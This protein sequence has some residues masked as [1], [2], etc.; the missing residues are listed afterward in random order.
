[1]SA[2]SVYGALGKYATSDFTWDD[3]GRVTLSGP[4]VNPSHFATPEDPQIFSIIIIKSI[5]NPIK[6]RNPSN[7]PFSI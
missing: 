5:P 3:P 4:L 2:S 7:P 6:I 1:M